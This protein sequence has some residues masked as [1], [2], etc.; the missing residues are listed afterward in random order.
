MREKIERQAPRARKEG[1]LVQ[2][3]HGEVLVYDLERDKAHC[4]NPTAALIWQ[5]CDG[6][7]TITEL[8]RFFEQSLATPIE[9]DL[10]WCALNQ[11][12]RDHL[13]EQPIAFP[14]GKERISRRELV[15]RLGIGAAIVIP[16]VT[17]IVAPSAA[18]AGSTCNT[19]AACTTS[20]DCASA[21]TQGCVGT[22]NKTC[23]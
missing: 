14:I 9:E 7:T 13:L 11:L 5:H 3:L 18:Y 19:G 22:T 23:Q 2:E 17:S 15:R 12:E 20:A 1:L 10:I 16:I 21:C 8:A 4:L 6:R